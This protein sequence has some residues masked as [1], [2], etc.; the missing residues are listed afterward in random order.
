MG[1]TERRERE[2][3]EL[4][5]KILD[6]AR[7]L[8]VTESAATLTM[9]SIAARIEYSATAIYAHFPDKDALLTALCDH[10]FTALLNEGSHVLAIAD[11]VERMI[12]AGRFYVEFALRHPHQYQFMFMTQSII[13]PSATS[14]VA[15]G[16][17][18][19]TVAEA[20]ASQRL[21]PECVDAELIAQA[22]WAT[23]HGVAAL[24]IV[25][26]F[27]MIKARPT[28]EI[29]ELAIRSMF[30]G[31]VRDPSAQAPARA[32][33]AKKRARKRAS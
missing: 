26:R 30:Y 2:K 16:L 24:H 6:A 7:E 21:R 9:R 1:S 3:A 33:P 15:Y 17:F 19:D 10:D 8:F 23:L 13:E 18:K 11:P 27:Q 31:L 28:L 14:H 12:A 5:Q 25:G 29:S 4:R 32:R 20:I 22:L